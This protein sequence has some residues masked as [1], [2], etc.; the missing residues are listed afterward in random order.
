MSR[1]LLR[2]LL[3]MAVT[4]L[5]VSAVLFALL[6]AGSGDVTVKILG[7]FS[8]PEQRASYRAQLGLEQ[9]LWL[10]YVSWLAGNDWWVGRRVGLPLR[11]VANPQTGEQEW[12]A[13]EG[14]RLTRW[15]R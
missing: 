8:T 13:E 9:P 6:E 11:R 3:S 4:M 7:Q 5:L 1:F 12:W 14:G 10:R 15:R 2:S